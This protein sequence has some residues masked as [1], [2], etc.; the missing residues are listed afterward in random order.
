MVSHANDWSGEIVS[1][2]WR[3]GSERRMSKAASST[4]MNAVWPAEVPAVWTMLFSH[5]L[6]VRETIPSAR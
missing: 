6:K 4:H 5:R 3:L 2:K 1:V